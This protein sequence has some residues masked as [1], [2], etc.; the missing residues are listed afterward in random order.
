MKAYFHR[1]VCFI[2]RW[3]EMGVLLPLVVALTLAGW[4]T[5]GGVAAQSPLITWLLELPVY[6]AYAFAANGLAYLAWRRWSIR[7]TDPQIENFWDR[8]MDGDRGAITVFIVNATFYLC[9]FVSLLW[10]FRPAR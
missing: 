6:S 7:L 3:Q 1:F 9:A 5:L 2:Q 4:T 10:F 8:L